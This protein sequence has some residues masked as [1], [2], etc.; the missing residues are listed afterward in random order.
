MDEFIYVEYKGK[1]YPLLELKIRSKEIY[2][3]GQW[4]KVA[5][6][7]FGELLE[8]NSKGYNPDVDKEAVEV[9]EMIYHHVP[10]DVFKTANR[11]LIA[12]KYLDEKFEWVEE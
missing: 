1:D 10:D 6:E 5:P 4:V 7:S 9:D 12:E 11:K 8:K 3:D 2:P